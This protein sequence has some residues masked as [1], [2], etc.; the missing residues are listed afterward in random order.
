MSDPIVHGLVESDLL[1]EVAQQAEVPLVEA[2]RLLYTIA[3]ADDATTDAI[4]SWIVR[5]KLR[6]IRA[7]KE[8]LEARVRALEGVQ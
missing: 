3:Y 7:E 1:V 4:L 6:V 2:T 8:K 5:E